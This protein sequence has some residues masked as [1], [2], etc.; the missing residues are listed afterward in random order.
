MTY[1]L[2]KRMDDA[3]MPNKRFGFHSFRAG[4]IAS[5]IIADRSTTDTMEGVLSKV[6]II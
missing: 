4:F 1:H 6:G 3:G 2:K 5:A